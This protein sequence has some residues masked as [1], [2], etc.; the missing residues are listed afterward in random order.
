MVSWCGGLEGI[1]GRGVSVNGCPQHLG[2]V[3]VTYTCLS[4][5]PLMRDLIT[6]TGEP[7]SC[8]R[9]GRPPLLGF[10]HGLGQVLVQTV[11][12]VELPAEA[13]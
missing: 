6:W 10:S 12:W 8:P 3:L 13:A 4:H 9:A 1:L 11:L 5:T 7:L 2:S